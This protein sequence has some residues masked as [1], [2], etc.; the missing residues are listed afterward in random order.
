[1]TKILVVDDE[2]DLEMLIK[3]KFRRQIREHLYEFLF[4]ANGLEALEK[5]K[6]S[7]DV[8]IVL[9]DINMPEMDGLTLLGKLNEISPI[10][11]TVMVSAYGDMEN[12]R[13]AMNKGAYDF[14]CKPVNF[15]DLDLTIAKTIQHVSQLRKTLQA[16]KENNI[17]RM[18]VDETVLSFMTRR[19][20]ETS[21]M[22]NETIDATIAFIDICG[23]TS[24]TENEPADI[25]VEM[26]NSYFDLMVKE[27]IAQ[28]GYIDKFIGDAVLAVFRGEF[29]LDRAIDA[30]LAVRKTIEN[31][32][33]ETDRTSFMPKVTIGINSGEMIC[34]NI[35]SST[36]RRLDYTVIGDV[37]NTAERLQES[38]E[39]NQI[40]ITETSY[41]KIKESFSCKQ[42][43]TI[44]LKN[45]IQ[46]VNIYEVIN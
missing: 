5:I 8:D 6:H 25:V 32:P 1:M 43:K 34:G 9:S 11:K 13:T 33:R 24:I 20:F 12:I 16:I 14:I 30:C 39:P 22:A 31:F 15:D 3:Q 17:L 26:L 41:H 35:G 40:L 27:I 44:S 42:V 45:K 29:H 2:A 46:P 10:I 19:E 36:L 4:A 38:A 21:L 28:G 7:Q 37:V 23:F 18:Y